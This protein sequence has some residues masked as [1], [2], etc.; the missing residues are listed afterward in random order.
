MA[1]INTAIK[2]ETQAKWEL[3][4]MVNQLYLN[5]NILGQKLQ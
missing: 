1:T 2:L 4:I 3:N 5:N